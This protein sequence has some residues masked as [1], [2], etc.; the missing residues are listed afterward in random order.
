MSPLGGE[1]AAI[2]AQEGPISVERY[3]ALAL[4]HPVHGYYMT[5]EPFGAAGDFV[6]A[7]EISQMFGELLGLWA[8]EAWALTGAPSPVRLVEI[9]PGRGTLM[10]DALRAAKVSQQFYASLDVHLVETSPRLMAEQRG[11]LAASGLEVSWHAS[12]ADVPDGPAIILANELFDALPVRHYVRTAAGWCE[13]CV[14]LDANGALAFGVSREPEP[15]IR[16]EAREGA[17]L[18]ISAAGYRLA[19]ML[20]ARLAAQGGAM[21]VVDYGH[22]ET[23]IGATL[24][25]MRDHQF[26]DPLADPGLADL[27]AHVDFA[28]LARAARAQGLDVQGPVTQG[29]FLRELGIFERAAALRQRATPQQVLALDAALQRLTQGSEGMGELFKAMALCPRGTPVM[30]GFAGVA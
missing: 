15:S 7:P 19:S 27:T 23:G 18:E 24:Q 3:M 13:R 25:A 8:A 29:A 6:T 16:N 20:A 9:G 5:R 14:G 26:V 2:I 30:P 17:V 11:T 10:K 22:T 21:L 28:A 12:I 1:I 4:S